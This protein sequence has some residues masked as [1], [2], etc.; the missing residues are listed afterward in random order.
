MYPEQLFTCT[1]TTSE[2]NK[3]PPATHCLHLRA[4]VTIKVFMGILKYSGIFGLTV[5]T[6]F[7][8]LSF[9]VAKDLF[10]AFDFNTTVKIQ[11]FLPDRVVGVFSSFSLLGS[12]EV[13]SVILLLTL[14][15]FRLP[16]KII[17]LVF[18]VL[19]GLIELA[20]KMIIEHQGPPVMFLKTNLAVHF[21]T[22]YIPHEFF[23]YPS[24]HSARTAFVSLVLI[25]A[26]WFSPKLSKNLKIILVLGVLAFD[27]IMFLSRVYLGE[28]WTTDVIGGILLGASLALLYFAVGNFNLR[29]KK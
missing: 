1:N 21:P 27:F 23:A 17:V 6:L 16:G 7:I 26:I 24:G 12:A 14:F 5:F 4:G 13:A 28:H 9:L 11:D 15:L 3:S 19:T 18:Y 22:S 29:P 20:G 2:V 10:T 25:F 8:F